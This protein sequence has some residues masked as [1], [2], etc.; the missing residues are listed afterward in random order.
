MPDFQ[1]LR[2]SPVNLLRYLPKFLA[3]DIVFKTIQD[4]LSNE[5]EK[6]RQ[7]NIDTVRQFF[8]NTATWGLDDWEIFL[9]IDANKKLDYQTRRNNIISRI[10]TTQTV[11][12]EFIN[13]LVNIFVADKS[14][15]VKDYPENY[16]VEILL[17]DGKVTSFK[18][19]ESALKIYMP[20]HIGWKYIGYV[21][22]SN[23]TPTDID[24]IT[25]T[26]NPIYIGSTLTSYFYTD[27][28]ADTT[29]DIDIQEDAECEIIGVIKTAEVI[30]IP[31]DYT[32]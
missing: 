19:L 30:N 5:H 12:L 20:A 24:G 17:P 3:K 9:G 21:E 13:Y 31:A 1:Y 32:N 2:I 16:A 11:T 22:P 29:Y 27:I 28:P 15:L 4:T 26:A 7:L 14:G 10:N 6:Q 23:D 8:V 18:D 25:T